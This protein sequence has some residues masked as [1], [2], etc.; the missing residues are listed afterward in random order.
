MADLTAREAVGRVFEAM[1]SRELDPL[2]AILDGEAEFHFP[3]T[4]PLRGPRSIARFIK[5][6]LRR[7]PKLAFTTG[8]VVAEAERAAVEWTNEGEDRKGA[9]Y[10]NAG[11]TVL[12]LREGR[13]VYMSDTF[14]DT[15]AFAR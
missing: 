15:G 4:E 12:E 3:G 2:E 7:F 8:W 13:I 14:K 10:R 9:P 1:N 11:V 5:I 6:L